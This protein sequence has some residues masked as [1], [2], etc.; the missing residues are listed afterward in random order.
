MR[1]SP[2]ASGCGLRPRIAGVVGSSVTW[3]NSSSRSLTAGA[4]AGDAGARPDRPGQEAGHAASSPRHAELEAPIRQRRR[5]RDLGSAARRALG[6]GHAHRRHPPRVTRSTAPRRNRASISAT[7][8]AAR[9]RPWSMMA[10][11]GAQLLQL[12]EDVAADEHGLAHGAQLAEQLAQLDARARVEAGRRLV[13]Q[14]HRRVVD[15]RV[16][17]AQPLL[18]APRRATGRSRRACAP[19]PP[20]PAGPRRAACRATAGMP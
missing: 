19:G 16:G 9:T 4:N 1:R 18:H 14:Q 17:E 3:R 6:G 11:R 5:G 15:E 2:P 12:G 8:P 7:S 10:T 20:A 13:E